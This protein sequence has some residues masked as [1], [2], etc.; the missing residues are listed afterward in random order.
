MNLKDHYGSKQDSV[1]DQ[2]ER[3]TERVA[4]IKMPSSESVANMAERAHQLKTVLSMA[5]TAMSPTC[6]GVTTPD[7]AILSPLCASWVTNIQVLEEEH[8]DCHRVVIFDLAINTEDAYI[9]SYKM[10]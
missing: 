9:Q 6:R 3:V 4:S 5:G 8:F 7:N 2:A 10:G 1:A